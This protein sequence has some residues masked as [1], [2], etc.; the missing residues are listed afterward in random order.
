M[1]N[2]NTITITIE[3]YIELKMKAEML[4]SITFALDDIHRELHDIKTNL[5][6]R[7]EDA[8]EGKKVE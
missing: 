8:L 7:I 4:H 5:V 2:T 3:D 1:E 6:L